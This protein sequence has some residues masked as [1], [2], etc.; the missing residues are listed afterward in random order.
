MQQLYSTYIQKAKEIGDKIMANIELFRE[1]SILK[2]SSVP[3]IKIKLE[4]KAF[5]Q[6]IFN[7]LIEIVDVYSETSRF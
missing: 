4:E 3:I 7:P 5:W 2:I 1:I 6:V